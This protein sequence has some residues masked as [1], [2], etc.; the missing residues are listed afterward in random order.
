MAKTRSRTPKQPLVETLNIRM[1]AGEKE[2]IDKVETPFLGRWVRR[3]LL[4]AAKRAIREKN[5][6]P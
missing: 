2:L 3:V 5:K 4:R 6:R 1:T